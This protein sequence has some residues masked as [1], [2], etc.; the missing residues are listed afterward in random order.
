MGYTQDNDDFVLV[1]IDRGESI[2]MVN[3]LI[4]KTKITY[5]ICLDE[6]SEIFELYAEKKAGVTRNVII[7]RD[8][9]IIFLTRLFD[10]DEFNEMKDIILKSLTKN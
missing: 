5:P 9:E 10:H 4:D 6:K 8:G 7:D 2:E 1:G 3:K